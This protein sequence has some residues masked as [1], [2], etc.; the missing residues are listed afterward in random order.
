MLVQNDTGNDPFGPGPQ[1]IT[2]GPAE[3]VTGVDFGNNL[4]NLLFYL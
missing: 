3:I 2:V 4:R 1:Q